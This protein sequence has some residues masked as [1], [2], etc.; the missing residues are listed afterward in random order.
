MWATSIGST[1]C[2]SPVRGERKS[3][4]PEGTEMPAPVRATTGPPSRT[5]SA[6]R[7]T[8]SHGTAALLATCSGAFEMRGAFAEEGGDALLGVLGGKG[9]GEADLLRLDPLVEIAGAR[10][11]LDLGD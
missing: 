10:D 7:A 6:R 8:P 11:A 4:M 3:G 9:R 1:F 5:S 2:H